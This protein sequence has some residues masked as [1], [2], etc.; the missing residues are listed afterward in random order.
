MAEEPLAYGGC[1]LFYHIASCEQ[2]QEPPCIACDFLCA[3]FFNSHGRLGTF[4]KVQG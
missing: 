4:E 2:T 3:V 1:G